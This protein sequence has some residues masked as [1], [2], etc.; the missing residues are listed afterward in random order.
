M[1]LCGSCLQEFLK[2]DRFSVSQAL[3]DP[4]LIYPLIEAAESDAN[5]GNFLIQYG[6]LKSEVNESFAADSLRVLR[7]LQTKSGASSYSRIPYS[8]T[9]TLLSRIWC[10]VGNSIPPHLL[11]D[12]KL[13][14]LCFRWLETSPVDTGSDRQ[15]LIRLIKNQRKKCTSDTDYNIVLLSLFFKGLVHSSATAEGK[16]QYF[17]ENLQLVLPLLDQDSVSLCLFAAL[18][19]LSVEETMYLWS[20]LVS[21]KP[22]APSSESSGVNFSKSK[23]EGSHYPLFYFANLF[24]RIFAKLAST[25][26]TP[27]HWHVIV[28]TCLRIVAARLSEPRLIPDTCELLIYLIKIEVPGRH[29]PS[30][31][32]AGTDKD[33]VPVGNAILQFAETIFNRFT[34][35]GSDRML[36]DP[37]MSSSLEYLSAL[38]RNLQEDLMLVRTGHSHHPTNNSL[39]SLKLATG[40]LEYA[41]LQSIGLNPSLSA[42]TAPV[43][44]IDTAALLKPVAPVQGVVMANQVYVAPVTVQAPSVALSSYQTGQGVEVAFRDGSFAGIQNFNNT[45]YL[46]S[47]LQSLFL[48]D[49]F[50]C[51]VYGFR[52]EKGEKTEEADF[53]QGTKIISGLQLLFARLIKTHHKYI[54]ISEFI[55]SLPPTYRS[56]E[57]QDVTESGRWLLD[58]MGGTDQSLVK[59]V[60]GGEMIHKTKCSGCNNITERK[61]VF[62]DLCVSVP[63]Q[64]EVL[65]KK[66]VTVQS[67]IKRMLKPENLTG[68][69]KYS[70]DTC[71]KKQD[72]SRWIELTQLPNHLM[73]VMHK[74]SFDIAT[75]DFKKETTPVHPED[76]SVD[77]I[78]TR[79]ELY[80]SILHYGESAMKG[81]YVALG[82]R[83]AKSAD[84]NAQWALMDDSNVT[85]L[86]ES[87]AMERLSGLHKP[88]DSAYVLFFK[89][90]RAPPAVNPRMPQQIVDEALAIE[91][92]AVHL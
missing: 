63:K 62:T 6:S 78:G 61:E 28:E 81:H 51:S 15:F 79:Y 33:M 70:C 8:A 64:A 34:I 16:T 57:Q 82:K 26:Q 56:G 46:S 87:D 76:G 69:N 38:I 45:C 23:F 17:P 22:L 4:G 42:A 3:A 66:K 14:E 90:A 31:L 53:V 21:W 83:S 43:L 30:L 49:G 11:K 1:S 91:A 80:G 60:F 50:A 7:H 47:F 41:R 36:R 25:K 54:E 32:L 92:A 85:M 89:S 52:L 19:R 68:D 29:L 2:I 59:S 10:Q 75:C 24:I 74:F 88:T 48:T 13:V 71:G 77:L 58:K 37:N 40:P 39:L 72:A 20:L 27:L 73:L 84:R 65:G 5:C 9:R 67:L 86:S 35:S 18:E 12:T 44:P 55:R